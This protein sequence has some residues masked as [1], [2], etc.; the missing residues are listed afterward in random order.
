MTRIYGFETKKDISLEQKSKLIQEFFDNIQTG[1]NSI[2]N[3]NW[4][5]Y[6]V[7]FIIVYENKAVPVSIYKGYKGITKKDNIQE[8]LE[9]Q[10]ILKFEKIKAIFCVIGCEP[11]EGR[12]IFESKN[13]ANLKSMFPIE[14]KDYYVM[15]M[16][17]WDNE[18][19]SEN[20]T[21]TDVNL[22]WFDPEKQ[23]YS[24]VDYL[25]TNPQPI[26]FDWICDKRMPIVV[27]VKKDGSK[28]LFIDKFSAND[29]NGNYSEKI[30]NK[31]Y[32]LYNGLKNVKGITV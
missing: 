8:L 13:Y 1:L 23:W 19:L 5:S 3:A 24:I 9:H 25:D 12:D 18:F 11:D 20:E 14:A 28:I 26:S 16:G 2:L 21:F 15:T 31:E 32:T 17:F 29:P 4:F 30:E 22:P 6:G 10:H 27:A 7:G